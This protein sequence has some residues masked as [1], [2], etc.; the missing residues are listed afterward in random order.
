MKPDNYCLVTQRIGAILEDSPE[1]SDRIPDYTDVNGDVLFTPAMARG[2]AFHIER[3]G[4]IVTVP[5]YSV[6]A[7]IVDG[8]LQHEGEVGIP[9]FAGGEGVNPSSLVYRVAYSRLKANGESVELN[10]FSFKAIPGGTVDLTTI[11]PVA[12][13]PS[14][15]V[16]KGDK[17][18]T[19]EQ[20]PQG[21]QGPQ[22]PQGEPGE[23]SLDQLNAKVPITILTG[24]GTPEGKVAAPVGSVYTDT[25]ATNGAIRWIKA[26]GT[27]NTG[28]RVEY[29]DEAWRSI[30]N[31]IDWDTLT[32]PGRYKKRSGSVGGTNI[33]PTSTLNAPGELYVAKP[34][35][36]LD[37]V[38]Q[39]YMAYAVGSTNV[40]S[41]GIWWR[42]SNTSGRFSPWE[43]LD[44]KSEI[45]AL[46]VRIKSLEDAPDPETPV[47]A[48]S[49]GDAYSQHEMRKTM[50][51]YEMGGPISTG[52]KAA[53]SFR[54]DH[55]MKNFS[56][57]VLPITR[58]A[59]LKVA[60]AVNPRNWA[61]PEND[62]YTAADLNQWVADG[63]VE[64]WNHSAS[65][66]EAGDPATQY[67]EI[68]NGLAELEAQVPAQGTVW[69][70]MPPGTGNTYIDFSGGRTIEEWDNYPAMLLLKHH[71]VVTGYMPNTAMRVLDGIPRDGLG[72]YTLDK[73]T[74]EYAKGRIDQ[75]IASKRGINFMVHPSL[76]DTEGCLTT[77]Q[78]QEIVDY[79]VAKRDAGELVT[80]SPY[81]M[82]VADVGES[83]SQDDGDTGWRN[84]RSLISPEPASGS[85]DI[86]RH[87]SDV[88]VALDALEISGD[89]T[90]VQYVK[91]LPAGFRPDRT[92]YLPLSP[93]VSN[94]A[95]G[96]VRVLSNG[97]VTIYG[98]SGKS[99]A[100]GTIRFLTSES[101]PSALPGA[102]V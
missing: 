28:W 72:H 53:I 63:D 41:N 14:P 77:A 66:I 23:V 97:T 40:V 51:M 49:T 79:V 55:G 15:G 56:E 32:E 12:G 75:A 16:T 6:R 78:F 31:D 65:H 29:D 58:A 24:T 25:A 54:F 36:G 34:N 59:N 100:T 18:D 37:F 48:E 19:G 5:V 60:Q 27:G 71:A 102:P 2:D 80:L 74:P 20:G 50:F 35:S 1:D 10:P 4:E 93:V 91:L 45:D 95:A 57:K 96:A 26:S 83:T 43:R 21:V 62:G 42:S 98:T 99:R 90:H 94:D 61:R 33:P 88:Y 68:V 67:D 11:T 7:K 8:I 81:E 92:L 87:G 3:D 64:V 44:T 9:L 70:F 17:G 46:A 30:P 101:W 22:G 39:I 52:G 73:Q 85:I 69:G 82:C 86:R 13:T 76:L 47:V 84:I 89:G 38:A